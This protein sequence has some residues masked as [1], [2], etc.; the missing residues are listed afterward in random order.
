MKVESSRAANRR[1]FQ[2]VELMVV[3]VI[4]GL[5]LAV[6]VPSFSHRN[7]WSRIEGAAREM[8]T[9]IQIT[10]Q[11]AVATRAP[12]RLV[13]D[14]SDL[15]YFFERQMDDS[16][17]TRDPDRVYMV[18]GASGMET[19]VGGSSGG[20]EVYLETRGTVRAQDAPTE[21]RFMNDEND[22]ATVVLVRTG[23]VSVRMTRGTP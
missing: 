19:E 14:T 7:S 21:V 13:L 1:G 15:C 3:L 5:A 4:I 10:R 2:L 20:T 12:Y 6:A 9:R 17:W 22:T 23:R 11:T 16:T 8:S 18:R